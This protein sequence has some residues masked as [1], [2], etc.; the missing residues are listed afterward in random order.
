MRIC[1][2]RMEFHLF[3]DGAKVLVVG[4]LGWWFFGRKGAKKK[5]AEVLLCD[6]HLSKVSVHIDVYCI[7]L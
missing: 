1:C 4:Y 5:K 7:I 3:H 2:S 6:G